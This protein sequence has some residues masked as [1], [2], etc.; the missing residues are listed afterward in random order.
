MRSRFAFAAT[1]TAAVAFVT[2]G[3]GAGAG[4]GAG[5]AAGGAA[6]IAPADTVAFVAIDSDLGSS[7]WQA[8]DGLLGKLPGSDAL[9]ARLRQSLE[10]KTGLNWTNDVRPA[11][12]SELDVAVLPAAN[13]KPQAVLLTQ[14]GNAAKLDALLAKLHTGSSAPVTT[15]VDGWTAISDSQAALDAVTGAASH[16]ADSSVYQEATGKLAADA[17]VR[18]YANGAEARQLVTSLG[19]TAPAAQQLVWAAADVVA[20][21]G[22]LKVDGY[23]RS[24]SAA[25][26]QP[27]EA[28][29]LQ[30]IPSGQLLVAD[31][32]PQHHA[33]VAAPVPAGPLPGALRKLGDALGGETA[34]Y[35]SPGAPIPA[36]TL[37]TQAS[38]PQPVLD[39]IHEVLSGVASAASDAQGGGPN[40]GSILGALQL[41]HA[42]V[43]S[44]LVVSTSQEQIDAFRGGGP[45]LAD[46]GSFREARSAS[47]MPAQTDG[48]VYADLTDALPALEGLVSLAGVNATSGVDLGALRTLTA[49]GSG[50]SGGISSF[51]VYLEV[52]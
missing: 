8:L 33:A 41:S 35:V 5:G 50:S 17:L 18:A 46:D 9:V 52:R 3:C 27:Y 39:A 22:G 1:A 49:Y 37:V 15:Q 25:A 4:T 45:K 21:S 28:A 14:P 19:G 51:T 32:R 7:Q 20:A 36:V 48:F 16:L 29:L 44:D 10:Q 11:L 43:G 42:T 24:D 23:V 31:F 26:V 2:A 47:G 12:G 38:D 34:L 30:K 6:A 40:L 13:A